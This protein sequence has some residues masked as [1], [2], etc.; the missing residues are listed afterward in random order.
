[1]F[2]LVEDNIYITKISK[3]KLRIIAK[4]NLPVKKVNLV[5]DI[6]ILTEHEQR[7]VNPDDLYS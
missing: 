6:Y 1:M 2:F 5:G 3:P 7:R 4:R